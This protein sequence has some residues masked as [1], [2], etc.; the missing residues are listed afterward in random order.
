MVGLSPPGC[1][2]D[3]LLFGNAALGVVDPHSFLYRTIAG[4]PVLLMPYVGALK[5]YIFKDFVPA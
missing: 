3:E 5:A 2:Y 4:V 1:H